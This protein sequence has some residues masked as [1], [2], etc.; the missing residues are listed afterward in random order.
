MN[1][2][3]ISISGDFK[4]HSQ[5]SAFTPMPVQSVYYVGF[6]NDSIGFAQNGM[7]HFIDLA[8][9]PNGMALPATT[10]YDVDY[11]NELTC[12]PD[13]V[14]FLMS[15]LSE[16]TAIN[17]FWTASAPLSLSMR[18][19]FIMIYWITIDRHNRFFCDAAGLTKTNH[20]AYQNHSHDG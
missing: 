12:L 15:R 8:P 20:Q 6:D 2:A 1:K 13:A 7:M 3:W 17:V 14:A 11:T 19:V 4:H 5:F 16:P 9:V 18:R 10:F